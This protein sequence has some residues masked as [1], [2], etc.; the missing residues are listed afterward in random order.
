MKQPLI[1][2]LLTGLLI[3][4]FLLG[5][6]IYIPHGTREGGIISGI[7]VSL[8]IILS[9]TINYIIIRISKSKDKE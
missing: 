8:I 1:S 2:G 5:K 3:I 7:G 9:I 6:I 4:L